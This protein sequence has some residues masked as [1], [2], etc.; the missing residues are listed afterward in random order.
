MTNPFV[1]AERGLS[2]GQAGTA[3]TVLLN[4]VVAG[5]AHAA[6]ALASPAFGDQDISLNYLTIFGRTGA[7]NGA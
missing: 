7:V 6:G 2:R 4:G 3:A 1:A 5:I